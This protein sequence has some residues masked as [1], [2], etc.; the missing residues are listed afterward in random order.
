[1]LLYGS[2]A[3]TIKAGDTRRITA[4]EMKYIRR[5]AG[6]IWTDYKTNTQIAKELKI[7]PILDKL[8]AYKRN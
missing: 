6:Y 2:E 3:W 4:A 5:T 7:T 8:L 1:V